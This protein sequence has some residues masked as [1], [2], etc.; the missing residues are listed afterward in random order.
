MR[1]KVEVRASA[2][3]STNYNTI[4]E[5][6][7]SFLRREE[8][9]LLPSLLN[10]WEEEPLLADA[11]ERIALSELPATIPSLRLRGLPIS[12]V[13]AQIHVYQCAYGE[14]ADDFTTQGEEGEEV[15]AAS[16]TALP[17][18][19]WEGLWE[20]LIYPDDIKMNLLNYIYSTVVFSNAGVDCKA[21]HCDLSD[22]F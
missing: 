5:R 15:L 16:D 18:R 1:H 4:R 13:S 14:D 2:T 6:V 9:V 22:G 17:T 10:G 11:V 8:T 3:T 21:F 19:H 20:S 7:A 12:Q